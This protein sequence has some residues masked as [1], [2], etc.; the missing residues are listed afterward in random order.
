MYRLIPLNYHH[1]YYFWTAAKLGTIRAACQKLF[2]AQ[3]TLTL[4]IKA[5]ERSFG[6]RLLTRSRSGVSLTPEGRIAF[7]YCE[8]IFTQGDELVSAMQPERTGIPALFRL[9]VAGPISRSFVGQVL[10]SLRSI[11]RRL[12]VSVFGGAH[13]ELR[14]RLE[15]HRIDLVISNVDL[16]LKMGVEFRS[17]LAATI[18][19]FFVAA[20]RLVRAIARFPR[21]MR[22]LPMI[23][24]AE[25]DPVRKDVDQ[26][27]CRK[28]ITVDVMSE[29]QNAD[30]LRFLALQ[31]QGIAAID[32]LTISEDLAF[33][34][35]I[36]LHPRP[37]G[38]K[39]HVWFICGRHPKPN[40]LLE[41]AIQGLMS[42]FQ[43]RPRPPN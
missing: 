17:S 38:I 3:P 19:V 12:R 8:R 4:Q 21:D 1:L 32:T 25:D 35:L 6:K 20:A 39:Q 18:P 29:V 24:P 23:L 10:K 7:Q 31:G 15:S 14:A 42:R 41:E 27:L 43:L 33:K 26:F 34:R 36:K 5:L 11:D 9:G 30:L 2:L 16:S 13:E 22:R 40:R 37:L 28:Q